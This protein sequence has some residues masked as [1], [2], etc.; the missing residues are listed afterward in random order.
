M[1][2]EDRAR[3][4]PPT[5]PDSFYTIDINL[6]GH[7]PVR[8][9]AT[10]PNLETVDFA[11]A[12]VQRIGGTSPRD[13]DFRRHLYFYIGLITVAGGKIEAAMK[14]AILVGKREQ[15]GE[16]GLVDEN[17]TTLEKE[18]RKVAAGQLADPTAG[19]GWAEA[20]LFALDWGVTEKAKERRDN[21]VHAYWW[22]FADARGARGRFFRRG[23][24][25]YIAGSLDGLHHDGEVL[26]TFA[27]MLE[28]L[29]GPH[30]INFYL[31][32]EVPEGREE[33]RQIVWHVE[34]DHAADPPD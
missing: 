3:W 30:W 6:D 17:W 13:W 24:S 27:D 19:R 33:E 7:E 20:V 25:A 34:H 23:G 12:V 9:S 18:L 11:S 8:V 1:T 22:D 16:M 21:A 14:R 29:S 26:L 15:R 32:R 5:S 2:P 10:V 31:P 4:A 28:A